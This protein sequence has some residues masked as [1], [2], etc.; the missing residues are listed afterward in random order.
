MSVVPNDE[1]DSQEPK[2]VYI[3][4]SGGNNNLVIAEADGS[5]RRWKLSDSQL[6]K[7]AKESG[8][9]AFGLVAGHRH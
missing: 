4:R 8:D 2:A 9:I 6:I 5:F 3:S 1:P 7:V